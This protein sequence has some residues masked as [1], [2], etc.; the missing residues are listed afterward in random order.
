MRRMF[1]S[2][3]RV[4]NIE[5]ITRAVAQ[6]AE[7]GNVRRPKSSADGGDELQDLAEV[8][9]PAEVA[10]QAAG[11]NCCTV[12]KFDAQV[13]IPGADREPVVCADGTIAA[14]TWPSGQT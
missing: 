8:G 11:S 2:E 7:I 3:V 9:R 5:T 12:R 4:R 13:G 1:A 6:S 10:A 14:R